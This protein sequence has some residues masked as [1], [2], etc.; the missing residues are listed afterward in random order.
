MD[1]ILSCTLIGPQSK[2][3]DSNAARTAIAEV[4]TSSRSLVGLDFGRHERGS[5]TAA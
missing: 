1:F 4:L 5:R 3:E 2:P